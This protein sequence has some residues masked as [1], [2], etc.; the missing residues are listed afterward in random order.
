MCSIGNNQDHSSS[1][2]N[3]IYITF[4]KKLRKAISSQVIRVDETEKHLYI[5]LKN[6]FNVQ[7]QIISGILIQ[8]DKILGPLGQT[9]QII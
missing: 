7:E 3:L 4:H 6:D 9:T 2:Q 8:I 5:D 1:V